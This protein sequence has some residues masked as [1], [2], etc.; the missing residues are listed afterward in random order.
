MEHF[1]RAANLA[2]IP[3]DG[4]LPVRVDQ[5][6]LVLYKVK[7]QVFASR[8]FCPHAG[9]P[10]SKSY[11]RGKYVRCS[12]HSWE[13]DVTNGE[14]TGNPQIRMRC[15]AVKVEGDGVWVSLTP[16]AAKQNPAPP[17]PSRDDA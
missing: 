1:V 15:F 2:D 13:F 11:F 7:D 5:E 3:A 6:D 8:D 10:L 9:Y 17:P 4:M 16:F 12:L 14:Y